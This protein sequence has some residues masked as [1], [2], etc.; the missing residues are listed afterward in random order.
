[1][2]FADTGG[3]VAWLHLAAT[4]TFVAMAVANA[5]M[6]GAGMDMLCS[7]VNGGTP[8]PGSMATMYLLMGA[9]HAGP[10]LR[11]FMVRRKRL[12]RSGFPGGLEGGSAHAN[13]CRCRAATKWQATRDAHDPA[14]FTQGSKAMDAAP[15]SE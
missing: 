13:A 14:P 11:M 5:A 6:L 12:C 15:P 3:A 4:P 10:W 2:R 8:L 7:A 9:V 1:M